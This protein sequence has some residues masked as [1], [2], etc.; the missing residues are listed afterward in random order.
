MKKLILTMMSITIVVASYAYQ[1]PFEKSRTQKKNSAKLLAMNPMSKINATNINV[2]TLT[3]YSYWDNSTTN[4]SPY[5]SFRTAYLN[6]RITSELQLSYNLLD[7]VSKTFYTYDN[8][9]RISMIEFKTFDLISHTFVN[10]NRTNYYYS[11]Y[12]SSMA[13][14]EFYYAGTNTWTPNYRT[15]IL[16]DFNF[17]QIKQSE[18][19][20]LNG[21][22]QVNYSRAS[23][24]SYYNNSK[25]ILESIDSSY[26]Q[27]TMMMQAVYKSNRTYNASGLVQSILNYSY[28]NNVAELTEVDSL[29][30]DN[31]GIPVSLTFHDP[32]SMAP[33]FKIHDIIW[34]GGF[35]STIDLFENQPTSY[36]Q[37]VNM[38]NTWFLVGRFTTIYPDNYGSII[39]FDEEY[40]NNAFFPSYRRSQLYDSHLN[41]IEE[42]EEEYDTSTNIWITRYGYKN[43]YQYDMSGN[44]SE[45]ITQYYE[46]MDTAYL[47]YQKLEFSDFISIVAGVNSTKTLET[48]LYPNPTSNGSVSINLNLEKASAITIEVIDLNGRIIS[49]QNEDFGQGLNTVQLDGLTQGLY[50]VVI[51]SDYG[52]SRTKLMVK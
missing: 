29:K 5:N 21:S 48:K 43:N 31:M 26:N 22:W 36:L 42:S 50:F 40:D 27:S 6:N 51:S 23:N 20:Y 10:N 2:P 47:N 33:M 11:N 9:N 15:I 35:N 7:T 44:M 34:S 3:K 46:S 25:K 16:Y 17:N 49:S 32:V 12:G 45:N 19:S 30:Y 37:S 39:Y 8:Q 41:G 14:T 38:N 18:E 13:L 1:N 24:I 28:N 4:W 52:V